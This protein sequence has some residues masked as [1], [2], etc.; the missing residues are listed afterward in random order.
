MKVI[1]LKKI[2]KLGQEGDVVSVKDGHARNFLFPQRCALE[3]TDCNLKRIEKI[4]KDKESEEKKFLDRATKL[5]E[6]LTNVSITIAVEAKDD[7]EIY[8][9]IGE[10]QILKSLNTEGIDLGG[11]KI[12]LT[13]PIKKVGAYTVQV[14]LYK[15]ISVDLR[16]WVV[17][18]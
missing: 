2:S 8:G 17:K 13:E 16:I 6:E 3:A 12:V 14:I 18:K 1:L 5:K 11:K 10:A 9:T 15:D 4:K 7:E